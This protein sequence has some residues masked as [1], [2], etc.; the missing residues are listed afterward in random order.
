[1][2]TRKASESL[3]NIIEWDKPW[4]NHALWRLWTYSSIRKQWKKARS[5]EKKVNCIKRFPTTL[6]A[7]WQSQSHTATR[8]IMIDGSTIEHVGHTHTVM[9]R[10]TGTHQMIPARVHTT[11]L[12]PAHAREL[13]LARLRR[14]HATDDAIHSGTRMSHSFIL[15]SFCFLLI[16]FTICIS[17][18]DLSWYKYI[19]VPYSVCIFP[20]SDYQLR[21]SPQNSSAPLWLASANK[22]LTRSAAQHISWSQ[23]FPLASARPR[24]TACYVTH[25]V[26]VW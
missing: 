19:V 18:F 9:S 10:D 16:I 5:H 2:C 6:Q 12:T 22:G 21:Y 4:Y 7:I 25:T 8:E 17:P 3:R 20:Q 11:W 13:A 24:S 1:M 15:L 14:W 23:P 26:I